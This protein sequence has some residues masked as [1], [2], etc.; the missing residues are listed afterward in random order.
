MDKMI[1]T[2][3]Y[4]RVSLL[5][6]FVLFG[7]SRSGHAQY[8]E[9]DWS[10]EYKFTNRK[11]GFFSE[12]VG[13]G[14]T[15]IYLLQRNISKSKPYD[16]AKLKLVALN[17][18]TLLEDTVLALKGFPENESNAAELNELDYLKTI[19]TEEAIFVFWR[20][21]HYSDFARH[22]VIYAQTF[23]SSLKAAL[24]LKK[25]FEMEYDVDTEASI[26]DS[27]RC[28]IAANNEIEQLV[29]GAEFFEDDKLSFR[30]ITLDS[31]L[32]ASKEKSIL[33]PHK[34]KEL[35]KST[36]SEY[37]LR[38]NGLL[39]VNSV[40]RYTNREL[41]GKDMDH[42]RTYLSLTVANLKSGKFH[43]VAIRDENKTITDFSY[44]DV[45]GKTRI[46][47]FFGD[48]EKDTTGIDDQGVFYVDIDDHSL[49]SSGLNFVY[50]ERSIKNRIMS[51]KVKKKRLED[52][53]PEEFLNSRFDIE[54]IETMADS[55][56]VLFF[57]LEYNTHEKTSRSDMNGE[58]VYSMHYN[59]KKS[60]VYAM[61]FSNDGTFQWA[62][63]F[64]RFSE[65]K[66]V[67]REDI[68]VV[69]KHDKFIVMFGNENPKLKSHRKKRLRHL[70]KEI[71]YAVIDPNSGRAKI[72]EVEVNEPKTMLKDLRYVD[73]TTVVAMDGKFYFHQIKVRQNPIWTAANVVFFPT[74]YYTILTGNTKLGKG[75][76][77]VMKVMPGKKPRRKR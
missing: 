22:E 17:K 72:Y 49:S 23:R 58:N 14:F 24:P 67:D 15:T 3:K 73:P 38:K 74:L 10:E 11:T 40:V 59:Y 33:L 37:E 5:L 76:F 21:L 65:Y 26:F 1:R 6:M 45:G 18:N 29:V 44:Q 34:L 42:P 20:K 27:S 61:R 53:S 60:N 56:L 75:D 4:L 54:H 39:Y 31:K 46:L 43:N 30:Y 66:G 55:S 7:I 51:K 41:E 9:F 63:S 52:L 47:G 32:N 35:P 25:V 77:T 69:F 28:V 8:M 2:F 13:T 36:T 50:F 70:K 68:Q 48:V 64:E 16:N 57:T 71:E 19:V 12:Y 62:R